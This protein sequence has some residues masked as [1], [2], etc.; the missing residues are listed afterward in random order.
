MLLGDCKPEIWDVMIHLAQCHLPALQEHWPVD[1][2]FMKAM[3]P[4]KPAQH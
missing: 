4:S 1:E 3:L 2:S